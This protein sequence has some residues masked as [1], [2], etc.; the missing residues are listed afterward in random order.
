[1]QLQENAG[2]SVDHALPSKSHKFQANTS[3][4]GGDRDHSKT[5]VTQ[6]SENSNF[7]T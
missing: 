5:P 4:N 2:N 6:S 3:D 1:M 7:L